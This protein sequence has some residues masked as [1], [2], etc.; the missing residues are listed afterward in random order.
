[1]PIYN[2]FSNALIIGSV[3]ISGCAQEARNDTQNKTVEFETEISQETTNY[4]IAPNCDQLPTGTPCLETHIPNLCKVG[5]EK[6]DFC[7]MWPA[8]RIENGKTQYFDGENLYNKDAQLDFELPISHKDYSG[9]ANVIFKDVWPSACE[10]QAN[11]GFLG[12][13][14]DGFP[15]VNSNQGPVELQAEY[16]FAGYEDARLVIDSNSREIIA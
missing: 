7:L 1:M 14:E 6:T 10:M 15:I 12:Y 5:Y 11:I 13:S 4:L 2:I 3:F 9:L 16:I 8:A